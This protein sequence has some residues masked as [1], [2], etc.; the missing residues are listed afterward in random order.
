M[1]LLQSDIGPHMQLLPLPPQTIFP[2]PPIYLLITLLMGPYLHTWSQN[3][4]HKPER[5]TKHTH[6]TLH[7]DRYTVS[8]EYPSPSHAITISLLLASLWPIQV[9]PQITFSLPRIYKAF[10]YSLPPC[11][12]LNNVSWFSTPSLQAPTPH[13]QH[14]Q[15]WIYHGFRQLCMSS[16]W[17]LAW[18]IYRTISDTC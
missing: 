12:L 8:L 11:H 3:S 14:T 7:K 1:S 16:T 13:F 2:K 17:F 4:P 6:S 15:F 18:V 5:S 9:T 10:N